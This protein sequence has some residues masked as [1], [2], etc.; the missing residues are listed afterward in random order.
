M[1]ALSGAGARK[2]SGMN[3][4]VSRSELI[5]VGEIRTRA[6]TICVGRG[7]VD[8]ELLDAALAAMLAEHRSL[9]SRIERDGDKYFLSLLDGDLPRLTVRADRPGALAQEDNTPMP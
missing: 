3:R 8:E 2:R 4:E 9:R 1:A 6:V 5:Y 7:G